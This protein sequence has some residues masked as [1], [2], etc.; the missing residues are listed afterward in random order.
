[1]GLESAGVLLSPGG[2]ATFYL[3]PVTPGVGT[4]DYTLE[5]IADDQVVT[6]YPIQV[7]A[8]EAV[9]EVSLWP[10]AIIGGVVVLG[11][12]ATVAL[13]MARPGK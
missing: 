9:P 4:Y 1:M 10:L 5:I 11:V 7:V 13:A 6:E 3:Y 8:S 2:E 12:G